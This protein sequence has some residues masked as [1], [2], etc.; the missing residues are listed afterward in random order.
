MIYGIFP[1]LHVD[2]K[3]IILKFIDK[4]VS[5]RGYAGEYENDIKVRTAFIFETYP[6]L[7]HADSGLI[8]EPCEHHPQI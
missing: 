4:L 2:I 3:D 5:C 1:M 7:K 6:E 8:S